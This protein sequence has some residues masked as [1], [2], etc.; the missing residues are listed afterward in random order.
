[1]TLRRIATAVRR[2]DWFTVAVETLIVVLGVFLGL[3]AN[4]WNETRLEH[5]RER[6]ILIGLSEDFAK[7]EVRPMIFAVIEQDLP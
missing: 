4:S 1:M 3:Q 5:A 7:L 2:Q 6:Q